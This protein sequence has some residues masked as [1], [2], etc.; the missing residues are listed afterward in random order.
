MQPWCTTNCTK[1]GPLW[2]G[3]SKALAAGYSKSVIGK[4]AALDNLHDNPRYQALMQQ[5]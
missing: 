4:A 1:P 5:K 2:S 3:S